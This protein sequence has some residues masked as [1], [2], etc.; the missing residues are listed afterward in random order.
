MDSAY[1]DKSSGMK[2]GQK[3]GSRN[4]PKITQV[5]K[6]AIEAKALAGWKSQIA[7]VSCRTV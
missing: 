1:K 7:Y 2:E 4:T 5:V 6:A 3:D